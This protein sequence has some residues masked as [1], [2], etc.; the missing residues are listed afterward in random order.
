MADPLLTMEEI[1]LRLGIGRTT[2]YR[3]L[4]R[5]RVMP[6]G[7]AA[8]AKPAGAVR[9]PGRKLRVAAAGRS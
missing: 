7:D 9:A 6:I 3:A 2:L 4:G 8:S 5:A 1:A